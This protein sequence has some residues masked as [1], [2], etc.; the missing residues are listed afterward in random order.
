MKSMKASNTLLKYT[1][2]TSLLVLG[3][4]GVK[5]Y[6]QSKQINTLTQIVN[7]QASKVIAMDAKRLVNQFKANGA[8]ST[9]AMEAF[10]LLIKMMEDEGVLVIDSKQT[11]TAPTNKE[12]RSLNA[13]DVIAMAKDKGVDIEAYQAEIVEEAKRQA[14]LVI[15][16]LEAL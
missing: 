5:T 12:F 8:S 9:E 13:K 14:D 6:Q 4:I 7:K 16:Q 3:L 2:A 10:G 15:K 1:L 11:I